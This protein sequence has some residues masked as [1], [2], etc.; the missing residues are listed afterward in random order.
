MPQN[1]W[2]YLVVNSRP[3]KYPHFF[4]CMSSPGFPSSSVGK[5]STCNSGDL[6]SIQEY[7]L[8]KEMATHFSILAWEIP[9]TEEPGGLQS[10]RITRV[11]HDLVTKPLHIKGRATFWSSKVGW[12]GFRPLIQSLEQLPSN[13]VH[14]PS[15]ICEIKRAEFTL[16]VTF[17]CTIK[18]TSYMYMYIYTYVWVGGP[19]THPPIPST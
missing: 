19:P 6:G 1:K 8:E 3:G 12:C 5:G 11:G 9:W 14:H 10:H 2:I 7:A 15:L 4:T 17:C 16:C 13:P 18:G